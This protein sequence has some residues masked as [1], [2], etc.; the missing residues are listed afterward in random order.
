MNIRF[1]LRC[2]F[3]AKSLKTHVNTRID[4]DGKCLPIR[5]F[6]VFFL[7]FSSSSEKKEHALK[8]SLDFSLSPQAHHINITHT[9]KHANFLC[10]YT[11]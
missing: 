2:N 1:V 4:I 8:Q 10:L 6:F 9:H 3:S 7:F 11:R 5:V